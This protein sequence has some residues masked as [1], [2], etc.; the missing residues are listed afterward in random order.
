MGGSSRTTSPTSQTVHSVDL[1]EYAEPYFKRLMDRSEAE[2]LQGYDPYGGQ[3]LAYF[4]PDELTAQA[5]GR[6]IGL[7]GTP[8]QFTKASDIYAGQGGIDNTLS[9]GDIDSGY[10]SPTAGPSAYQKPD[11]LGAGYAA[12]TFDPGYGAGIRSSQYAAGPGPAQY[13]PMAYEQNIQRFMSPYQQNVIDIEKREARRQSA[14]AAKKMQDAAAGSGGLGGYREAIMQAGRERSL[15]RQLGDIQQKGSQ[16]AFQSAQQQLER[17]RADSARAAQFGLQRFGAVQSAGQSQ[18]QLQQQAF[19]A[20]EAARQQ[21]AQLGLSAQQQE[22]AARRAQEQF[23]QS[24]FAQSQQ[25]MQAAGAQSIEAFQASEAAKQ[26]AAKLGL[27]AEQIE[28]AGR[29]A[30]EKFRQSAFD[31]SSRYGLA[32]AQGLMGAGTAIQEDAVKRMQLMEGIGK[33]RRALRQAGLDVGYEDYLR[34][35]DW[36]KSQLGFYGGALRGVPVS[37]SQAISTYEQQP[38]LFQTTLGAGLGALGLWKGMGSGG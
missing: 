15:G 18:E 35:R 1:P 21:A 14:I 26:Q 32:S 11:A 4:S 25:A 31:L 22:D 7:S 10:T 38:G 29:Q 13:A 5:M 6:G 2:S 23:T 12:G 16:A 9:Q 27:S 20:G 17:E 8:S 33:Q 28:Q 30:A 34:Q 37:P 36:T 19:S 3:R 24:A